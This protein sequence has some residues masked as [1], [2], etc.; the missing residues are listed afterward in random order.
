MLSIYLEIIISVLL[1]KDNEF[2]ILWSGRY[3]AGESVVA[4][5]QVGTVDA[6]FCWEVLCRMSLDVLLHGGQAAAELQAD[7]ALVGC[8]AP[9]CAEVLDHC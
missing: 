4:G 2:H 8:S 5:I 3:D 1:L 7:G 6:P 9:M